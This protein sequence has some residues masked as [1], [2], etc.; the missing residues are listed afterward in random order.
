MNTFSLAFLRQC[1]IERNAF[2]YHGAGI[3]K[4]VG[5][6][7]TNSTPFMQRLPNAINNDFEICCSIV[8]NGDS[9]STQNYC[10]RIGLIVWPKSVNSV[11]FVS[12]HDVGTY[13]D[14]AHSGRRAGF[15]RAAIT[16]EQLVNSIDLRA[17]DSYNEW[18][19][20]DY[21]VVGVFIE[22]DIQYIEQ[23]D[24]LDLP[25]PKVFSMFP[26]LKVYAFDTVHSG[27]LREVLPPGNWGS[28]VNIADLYQSIEGP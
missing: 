4:G 24:L 19:L 15:Q 14:P 5:N 20:L 17:A 25:V 16:S 28:L 13:P 27:L 21:K 10:G 8:K 22:P 9:E 7:A 3:A 2:I 18:C 26:A 23:G 11:T 1:L 6:A 12:P